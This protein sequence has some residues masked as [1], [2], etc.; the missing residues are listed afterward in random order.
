MCARL[1]KHGRMRT[2]IIGGTAAWHDREQR[3]LTAAELAERAGVEVDAAM[4][5]ASI[6]SYDL[7]IADIATLASTIREA[8]AGGAES[9]VVMHGTDTMEESAWLTELMFG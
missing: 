6:P 1:P 8:I 7:S 4:D 2:V 3:M 9:V 5:L